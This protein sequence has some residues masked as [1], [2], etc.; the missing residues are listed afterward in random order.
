MTG[1][2]ARRG[3]TARKVD[4]PRGRLSAFC[5]ACGAWR[6]ELGA[7]PTP[8]L[9][10]EHMVAVF[11]EVRRVLH[12]SGTLWL[13]LGDSFNSGCSSKGTARPRPNRSATD[14]RHWQNSGEMGDGRANAPG[15]KPKDLCGIPWQV[16]FALRAGGWYLR[17]EIIWAKNNPMPESVT[18]RPTRAHE[19]VFLLAKEPRY[20]FDQEAVRESAECDRMR[21]PAEHPDAVSTNGN[22][23]LSRREPTGGRN[24]RSVW[25]I[26]THSFS[27]AHFATFP[28]ALAERCI[29]AGSSERGCCPG[30]GAPWERIVEREGAVLKLS[31]RTEAKRAAGLGT[32][33]GGTQVQAAT[34][35]TLGWR[36]TCKC[37]RHDP[38]PSVILDPFGG[39]MTT[40]LVADRLGRDAVLCELN[41]E[42]VD[43]GRKRVTKDAGLFAEVE[44]E[45]P[46]QAGA[47][48]KASRVKPSTER[49][50]EREERET[51][52]I[53]DTVEG[54]AR[55]EHEFNENWE[56]WAEEQKRRER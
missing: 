31:E 23:G 13:N 3:R 56:R 50:Q 7:E 46:E 12:P 35:R 39:A 34:S 48:P 1:E 6:G 24:I 22:S 52:E 26:N 30:C 15:L 25:T 8:E 16:A 40:G 44:V 41:P 2:S 11:R 32:A 43:M 10:V 42:Y 5:Q 19:Q 28:P 14:H 53:V 9:Y 20:Y 45:G 29:K 21:G 38:V 37:P 49:L 4:G 33:C 18:D 36:K 47:A 51:R 54:W 27:E 17:S 55:E